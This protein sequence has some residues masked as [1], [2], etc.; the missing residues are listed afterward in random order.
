MVKQL[1]KRLEAVAEFVTEGNRLVDVGT[2]HG[3][4]P[5]RLVQSGKVPGAI[6]MDINKGPLLHADANIKK[7]GLEKKIETRLSNGLRAYKL[8]EADSVVIAGMGGG[9]IIS[10]LSESL[11][12]LAGMELILSPQSEIE[13]V[14]RFLCDNHFKI[15]EEAMLIDEGKYYTIIKAE[16]GECHYDMTEEYRYGRYLLRERN[17]V[18]K[19]FLDRELEKK[20]QIEETIH[21]S[22]GSFTEKRLE[23]ISEEKDVILK[24]LEYYS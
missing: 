17:E 21:R 22:G 5:I 24:A 12:K 18:L 10:I 23:E 6:A 1:S 11:D 15:V 4:V 19:S 16:E 14:R 13:L 7:F 3:H 2:D 8:G 9:L 20:K